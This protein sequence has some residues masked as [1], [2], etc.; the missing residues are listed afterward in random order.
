MKILIV[1]KDLKVW[2]TGVYP[3]E[4]DGTVFIVW[5]CTDEN[6]WS[7]ESIL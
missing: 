2:V 3:S 5:K 7:S 4:S 1:L 6:V